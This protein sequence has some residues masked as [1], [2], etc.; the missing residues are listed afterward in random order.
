MKKFFSSYFYQR[1][2]FFKAFHHRRKMAN[3]G[4]PL[5]T[6]ANGKP[7]VSDRDRSP[8]LAVVCHPSP[9]IKNL[10][11]ITDFYLSY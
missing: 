10:K 3:S 1:F 8:W 2:E 11:I 7:F 5:R 9:M 4:E 6:V